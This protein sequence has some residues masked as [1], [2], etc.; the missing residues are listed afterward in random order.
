MPLFPDLH[1][2]ANIAENA[3]P[4][5]KLESKALLQYTPDVPSFAYNPNANPP[6]LM[7]PNPDDTPE[8]NL[9]AF[10]PLMEI[11][12]AWKPVPPSFPVMSPPGFP[13]L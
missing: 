8:T 12:H 2:V 1:C 9:P 7:S 4:T 10:D 13:E 3:Y 6:V 5:V 11:D